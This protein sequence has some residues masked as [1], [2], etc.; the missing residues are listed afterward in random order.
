MDEKRLAGRKVAS[1]CKFFS[2]RSEN[3]TCHLNSS[4]LL[5]MSERNQ[6]ARRRRDYFMVYKTNT[7]Q[8]R[9][10][11]LSAMIR[12]WNALNETIR[13]AQS[14]QSFKNQLQHKPK[15]LVIYA[16]EYN[17]ASAIH[18]AR[19]RCRNIN[20]NFNLFGRLMADSPV[21]DIWMTK[22]MSTSSKDAS[23]SIMQE[24]RR[25]RGYHTWNGV[26]N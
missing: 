7:E 15:P 17:R 20:L 4:Q 9:S 19:L 10:S 22:P 6:Y 16:V 11:F 5:L 12:E 25:R 14:V 21:C 23:D 2:I 1:L 24:P 18:M 26:P 8:F 13:S 3:R